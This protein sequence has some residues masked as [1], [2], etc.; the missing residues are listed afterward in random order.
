MLFTM[1]LKQLNTSYPS[2]Y[3]FNNLPFSLSVKKD[4]SE[5]TNDIKT[6]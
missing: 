2:K 5:L 6:S 1:H 4:G 3:L